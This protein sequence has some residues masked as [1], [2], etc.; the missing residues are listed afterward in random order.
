MP[1]ADSPT[2]AT[3]SRRLARRVALTA[4]SAVLALVAAG[5]AGET[6]TPSLTPTATA[7]PVPTP[8]PTPTPAPTATPVT[9]ATPVASQATTGR[10]VI[11]GQGFA[12][13]LPDGWESIPVD[14]A[15]LQ[16]FLE[17]LPAD[18]ELRGIVEGQAGAV[19]QAIKFWAFDVR[20]EHTAAGFARNVN[21]IVQPATSIS[22]SAIE[23]AAKASLEA[24]AAIRKP[25]T[26]AV[27]DLPAGPALRLDYILDVVGAGG[28]TTSV[29]G[30][31]YYVQ[32]PNATLIVSFSTDLASAADAAKDFNAIADS[33]ESVS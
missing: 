13:T 4:A 24:I 31:Q 22:L 16:A 1:L 27:V 20:P 8:L 7:T 26:S 28:T 32:L 15:Q 17:S 10:I 29:A 21:I 3:R 9:T 33:I 6:A 12:I 14:P 5:C 11:A 18:S 23:S 25:V 19:Q 30:T 2:R